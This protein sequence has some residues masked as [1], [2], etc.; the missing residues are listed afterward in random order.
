MSKPSRPAPYEHIRQGRIA[1]GHNDALLNHR[2]SDSRGTR[3]ASDAAL[4]IRGVVPRFLEV[5][6]TNPDRP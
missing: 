2:P 6:A 4:R 5:P 1:R 3:T